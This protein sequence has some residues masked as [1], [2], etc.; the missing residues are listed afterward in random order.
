MHFTYILNID[1]DIGIF[2]KYHINIVSKLKK[3]YWSITSVGESDTQRASC[4]E[5]HVGYVLY[6]FYSDYVRQTG[7]AGLFASVCL[8]VC[9]SVCLFYCQRD[10]SKR[11]GWILMKLLEEVGRRV[12]R[13]YADWRWLIFFFGGGAIVTGRRTQLTIVITYSATTMRMG[14]ETMLRA[15]RA[16]KFLLY[17]PIV[18]FRRYISPSQM[19]SKKFSNKFV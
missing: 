19:K 10:Y 4:R 9:V 1:I 11:Y 5:D 18:T 14:Y 13:L 12:A 7:Y 2:C 3:W 6:G 16:E 8:S 15:E 17:T